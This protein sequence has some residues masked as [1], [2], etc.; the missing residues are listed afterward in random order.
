ML[1]L[2][3]QHQRTYQ[4]RQRRWMSYRYLFPLRLPLHSGCGNRNRVP[5]REEI[6]PACAIGR[7]HDRSR[8]VA[9]EARSV[10]WSGS[11]HIGT[12]A[13]T[14][15]TWCS[16]GTFALMHACKMRWRCYFPWGKPL[17]GGERGGFMRQHSGGFGDFRSAVVGRASASGEPFQ[18]PRA[19]CPTRNVDTRIGNDP[20]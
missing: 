1:Y 2:P 19:I 12:Y 16:A 3:A 13:W 5:P 9:A 4:Q 17:R 8:V 11:K 14:A 6:V 18:G 10:S 7:Y 20:L 15:G